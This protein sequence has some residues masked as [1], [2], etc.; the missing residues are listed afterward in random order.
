MRKLRRVIVQRASDQSGLP[1]EG[2]TDEKQLRL[3]ARAA[4]AL[5]EP[6]TELVIRAGARIL[7]VD[8]AAAHVQ[9]KQDRSPVTEA[10]FAANSILV[11]GLSRLVPN[12][13]VIS[14]ECPQTVDPSR[15]Q[16]FYL[17]DPLDGTKEFIAG[18]KEYT[19][20]VALVTGGVPLL[21]V[22]GAPALGMLWRGIVG[23]GA[24]RLT[25]RDGLRQAPQAIR[26][27]RHPPG[28]PSLVAVSRSHSDERTAAM[29]RARGDIVRRRVG[30]ALKF[31][32]V[33]EGRIDAY[34]RLSPTRE[35]DVAAGHAIVT[36]AGGAVT[37]SSGEPIKFGQMQAG[38]VIPEFVAWGDPAPIRRNR[39]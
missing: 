20:N 34:P 6:L 33:A 23:R 13:L 25:L 10:D 2:S 38:F 8:R 24:E 30:S 7:A 12:A 9:V 11:D 4:I 15:H 36:A 28:K 22:I 29:I 31:A 32:W 17:V 21:G 18:R 5:M 14:E 35:W 19:V 37:D 1:A 16:S 39:S 27:R 3:D 26:S